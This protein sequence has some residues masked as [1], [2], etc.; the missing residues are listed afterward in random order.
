VA[1]SRCDVPADVLRADV[2]GTDVAMRCAR[3]EASLPSPAALA[4][5][6]AILA[7]LGYV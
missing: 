5:K 1:A 3:C 7:V 4:P 6:E 2:H